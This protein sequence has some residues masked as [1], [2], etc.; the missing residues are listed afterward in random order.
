MIFTLEKMHTKHEEI[1]QYF[2]PIQTETVCLN[3]F[4]GKEI[5]LRWTGIITCRSC[6]KKTK[7][8]FGEGFCFTCF[9]QA[10]EAS[11]CILHPELCEAHLG[12]GRDIEYELKHHNQTHFVYLAATDIVK[13]GVTRATQVPTR[14]ID[15]GANKAILLAEVPNRY[16]AGVIE[17]ALK[18]F[19]A[20]KTNWQNMLRNIQDDSIDLVDE[21]W[22]VSEE[23]PSDLTQYWIENDEIINFQYPV[24]AY[25]N[26]VQS[27]TF[28]KEPQISGKLIGIRGQYVYLDEQKVLNLRRHTGYE[29]EFSA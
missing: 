3:D 9:N 7:K 12:K 10:A 15:Q 4:I 18:E 21:K 24:T 16:L 17:V 1:V 27:L 26:K 13:V 6:Q 11:P 19:F 20:D 28:D 14:W 22:Q 29:I 5:H 2:L 23:L 25:P 8:S